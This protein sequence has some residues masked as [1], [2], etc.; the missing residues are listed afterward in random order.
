MIPWRVL[1]IP[2]RYYKILA[3]I[4]STGYFPIAVD[5]RPPLERALSNGPPNHLSPEREAS[6]LSEMGGGYM[7]EDEEEWSLG[8]ED[9]TPLH[10]SSP[11]PKVH[12]Y[13]STCTT[14]RHR[15]YTILQV[16]PLPTRDQ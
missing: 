11:N 10:S 7:E 14:C 6:E 1:T 3:D 5:T 4:S 2:L 8:Y 13:T 16:P 9:M 12:K 15:Q